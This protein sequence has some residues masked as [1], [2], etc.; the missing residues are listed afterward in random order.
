M[1]GG[2]PEATGYT[3][4]RVKK[5]G[6]EVNRRIDRIYVPQ[7]RMP[8]LVEMRVG[9]IAGSDHRAVHAVLRK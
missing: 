6:E 8:A 4:R 1:Y 7:G 3:R 9:G 2:I 5:G